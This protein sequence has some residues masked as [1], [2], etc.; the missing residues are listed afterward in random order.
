[1]RMQS[2]ND[3]SILRKFI[4]FFLLVSIIPLVVLFYL[5]YQLHEYNEI[6]LSTDDITNILLMVILGIV[7]GYWAMR[8]TIL[9]FIKTAQEGQRAL[10]SS[11]MHINESARK[12]ESN[13]TVQLNQTFQA[14]T[15]RLE[16][17]RRNL[18]FAKK[19]LHSVLTKISVGLSSNQ[20]INGFMHLI[21]ET[22]SEALDGKV[23]MLLILDK[24]THQLQIKTI[25]GDD[26]LGL[27][28]LKFSSENSIF[29]SVIKHKKSI[30]ISSPQEI[31]DA[32]RDNLKNFLFPMICAP[33]LVNETALGVLA[34]C[35]KKSSGTFSEDDLSLL[36]NMALQSGVALNNDELKNLANIDP[37]TNIFKYR[38]MSA[39]LD[40]E[41]MRLKRYPGNL[42]LILFD[43]DGFK[44]YNDE[45]GH[46]EGDALL[47]TLSQAIA[48]KLRNSDVF[49]RYGGDEFAIILP[50]TAM[51]GALIVANKIKEAADAL[52][53]KRKVTLSI[54]GA[55]WIHPMSR[56][57]LLVK[58]DKALYRAKAQ[59][60]DKILLI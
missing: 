26:V 38:H 44:T 32:Q 40:Y 8:K 13:E 1:M 15:T 3:T 10:A 39:V 47:T 7:C 30:L 33:L 52:V 55:E 24:E 27:S 2:L 54:G 12:L 29:T 11:L 5:Y 46:P 18:E 25:V 16:E 14:V 23:G 28:A 34:I 35:G 4:I 49:C 36:Y 41:T 19:T 22:A 42:S 6:R 59:G 37:L 20:N 53:L 51:P 56:H 58:A 9:G 45:Y 43:V 60:K 57:D 17:D 48:K 21:V 50:Q 31:T